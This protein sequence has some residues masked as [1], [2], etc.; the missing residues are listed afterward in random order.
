MVQVAEHSPPDRV[1]KAF[2]ELVVE[3]GGF[4]EAGAGLRIG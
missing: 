2:Q 1:L 3:A 4:L